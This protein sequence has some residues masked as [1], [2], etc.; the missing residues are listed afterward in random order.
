PDAVN[1]LSYLKSDRMMDAIRELL[2]WARL[3]AGFQD[4]QRAAKLTILTDEVI[5]PLL[6]GL[7]MYQSMGSFTQ[8]KE[9]EMEAYSFTRVAT[10]A[11][12]R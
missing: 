2:E 7:K 12:S 11:K 8:L 10:E 6:E 3:M 5:F 9:G 4:A 1:S